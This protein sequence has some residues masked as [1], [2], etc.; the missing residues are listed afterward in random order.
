MNGCLTGLVGITSGA[1]TVEPWAAVVIG[2]CAGWVYLAGS[3]LLIRF[4]ID[5]AVD[6]IPVHMGGGAW[7]VVATG[8]FSSPQRLMNFLGTEQNVGWF[9]EWVSAIVLVVR[10]ILFRVFR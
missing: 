2:I 7:G 3:S 4:R 1:A 9:Y 5:D 10:G 6:A 8:L